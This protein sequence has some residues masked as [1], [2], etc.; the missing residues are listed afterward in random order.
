MLA[1]AQRSEHE[2]LCHLFLE[3]LDD[4]AA[5]LSLDDGLQGGSIKLILAEDRMRE[6]FTEFLARSVYDQIRSE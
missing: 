4:P 6:L 5:D 2:V 3:V 1:D